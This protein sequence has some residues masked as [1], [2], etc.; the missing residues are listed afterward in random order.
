MALRYIVKYGEDD[1]LKKVCRSQLQFDD[2]L[3]QTLD[4][5]AETMYHADGVGLAAPQIGV[6]RRYCVVDV[7]D[8][9]IE[10]VNPVITKQEGEQ[11]GEEGCLSLPGKYEPVKR[12]MRVTVHGQ[13]RNGRPIELEAEGLK[14]RAL[15]HE[16]DHL[17]G[18][19]FIDRAEKTEKG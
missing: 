18:I 5:M 13:D 16:I 3:A 10:L 7:G 2:R 14:A 15:C 1:I 8:G 4:D 11:S 9:L 6:L 19:L 17:N 12:P